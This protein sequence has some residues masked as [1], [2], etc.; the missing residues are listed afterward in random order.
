M[1]VRQYLVDHYG[2]DDAE[3]KTLGQGK[4]G[5]ADSTAENWGSVKI[6]IFPSGTDKPA[7]APAPTGT[8][9]ASDSDKQALP[10]TAPSPKS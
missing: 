10:A 8:G 5:S 2:F 1:V 9:A 6:L 4:Q 3:V 7:D